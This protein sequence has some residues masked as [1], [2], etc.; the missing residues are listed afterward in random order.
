MPG[1]NPFAIII[2]Q[3]KRCFP[4]FSNHAEIFWENQ[5]LLYVHIKHVPVCMFEMDLH[6]KLVLYVPKRKR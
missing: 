5:M 4:Y 1:S 3:H 2:I 6:V